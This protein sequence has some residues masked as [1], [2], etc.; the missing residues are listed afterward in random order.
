MNENERG[1]QGLEAEAE[2]L[3]AL[4]TDELVVS[5]Y[6]RRG[7]VRITE[8]L[9]VGDRWVDVEE[10]VRWRRPCSATWHETQSVESAARRLQDFLRDRPDR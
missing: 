1:W 9:S 8:G 4:A 2:R 10:P 7:V 3:T 6:R 5:A